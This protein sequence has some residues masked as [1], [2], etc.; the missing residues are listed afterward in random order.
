M[1]TGILV[2]LAAERAS[3]RHRDEAGLQIEVT[4]PNIDLRPNGHVVSGGSSVLTKCLLSHPEAW[5]RG[6]C[7]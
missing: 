4:I 2:R 3:L 1:C 7:W 6:C 5:R